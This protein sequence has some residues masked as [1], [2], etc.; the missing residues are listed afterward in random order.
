MK[1]LNLTLRT[2]LRLATSASLALVAMVASA[3]AQT[4]ISQVVTLRTGNDA[5]GNFLL[6]G[7]DDGNIT[8]SQT[9]GCATSEFSRGL[10]ISGNAPKVVVPAYSWIGSLSS[11][12][13]ARWIHSAHTPSGVVGT[14]LPSGSVQYAHPFDL[15]VTMPMNANVTIDME[16]A[17]DDMVGSVSFGPNASNTLSSVFYSGGTYSSSSFSTFTGTPTSLGLVPGSNYLFVKQCD[18]GAN[19]SGLIYSFKITVEYCVVELDLRSGVTQNAAG[20]ALLPVGSDDLNVMQV[21]LPSGN[22]STLAG[23]GG[24]AAKRISPNSAWLASLSDT[25]GWINPNHQ[26]GAVNGSGRAPTSALYRHDFQLPAIPSN[27]TVLLDLE[28]AAD[29]T[30]YGVSLNADVA[31]PGGNLAIGGGLASEFSSASNAQFV[32]NAGF[33]GLGQGTNSLYLSQLEN[34]PGTSYADNPF[35]CSG[36]M[37]IAKLTITYPCDVVDPPSTS[38][39]SFCDCTVALAAPCGNVGGVDQGCHNSTGLGSTITSSGL[40]VSQS[41]QSGSLINTFELHANNLPTNGV[42]FGIFIEGSNTLN[43]SPLGDGLRCIGQIRRLSV[44]STITGEVSH[45]PI[46]NQIPASPSTKYYQLWYRDVPQLS[47]PCQKGFNLSNAI[48]VNWL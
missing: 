11:D 20:T 5:G 30:L 42:V 21:P 18:T 12:S 26:T 17:A 40:A 37:Y 22:Y 1:K 47:S 8:F 13:D 44:V 2:A 15:P 24:S 19:F 29:E 27:A 23:G 34:F 38:F 39:E 28:W 14:G 4:S 35:V 43:L 9:H 7:A 10:A 25:A 31:Q 36:I 41:S 48:G 3:H 45:E 6:P 46:G 33:L 16:I 32:G